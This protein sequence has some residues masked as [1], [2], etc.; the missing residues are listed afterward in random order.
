MTKEKIKIGKI[1]C[2]NCG[3]EMTYDTINIVFAYLSKLDFKN[4]D[5]CSD[6]C[7]KRWVNK[8]IK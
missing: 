1:K 4:L 2:D 3:K 5:F 7:L 8:N 6:K